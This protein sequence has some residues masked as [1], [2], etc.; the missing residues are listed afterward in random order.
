MCCDSGK[1]AIT[2]CD[3]TSSRTRVI[4]IEQ[5]KI[6]LN[7]LNK[8]QSGLGVMSCCGAAGLVPVR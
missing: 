3:A 2:G 1:M 5:M 6:A 8:L 7:N 4:G